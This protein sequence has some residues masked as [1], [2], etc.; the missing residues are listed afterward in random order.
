[1]L[2]VLLCNVLF[3]CVTT[4]VKRSSPHPQTHSLN[5]AMPLLVDGL[6]TSLGQRQ[7][8]KITVADLIGPEDTI[9]GLGEYISEKISVKLFS[10]GRFPD[11][12]ERRQLKQVIAA[13]KMENSGYFDRETASKFGK[14]IGVDAMVIGV[15]KDLGAYYDVT[16]KMVQSETG[17]VLAMSESMLAKDEATSKL[18][19]MQGTTTLTVIVD[20][21][22]SGNVVAG[23][24]QAT[25]HNGTASF[26]GIPYGECTVVISPDGYETVRRSIPIRSAT[27]VL[28]QKLIAKKN[29]TFSAEGTASISYQCDPKIESPCPPPTELKRR[30]IKV[31]QIYALQSLSQRLGVDVN[32]LSNVANGRLAAETVTTS[33]GAVLTGIRFSPPV[34]KG[35]EVLVKIVARPK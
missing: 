34:I 4:D 22:T 5:A 35:D 7:A 19:A 31:A 9:T 32:T 33:S 25:L 28:A 27:E 10:S 2:A 18:T 12:M 11:F 15:V 13:I 1:M 29:P 21:P 16:V 8:G 6:V 26:N 17:A 24:K 20:P 30:A 23:G 14:M 3:S